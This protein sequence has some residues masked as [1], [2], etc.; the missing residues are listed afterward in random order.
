VRAYLEGIYIYIYIYREREREREDGCTGSMKRVFQGFNT[1]KP[2]AKEDMA[3]WF[4]DL[5]G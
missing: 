3:F 5:Y 4:L 1:S 2:R